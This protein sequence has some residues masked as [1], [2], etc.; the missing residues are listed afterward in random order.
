LNEVVALARSVTVKL[1]VGAVASS[2]AVTV[3]D[4]AAAVGHK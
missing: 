4:R 1:V 2:V 3:V